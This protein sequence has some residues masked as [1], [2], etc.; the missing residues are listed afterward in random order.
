[1]CGLITRLR[2]LRAFLHRLSSNAARAA[3]LKIF[4]RRTM[5]KLLAAVVLIGG[6]SAA[7]DDAHA[8]CYRGGGYYGSY[9]GSYSQPYGSYQPYG[10]SSYYNSGPYYGSSYYSPGW[11]VGSYHGG[12]FYGGGFYGGGYHGG[13][14]HHHHHH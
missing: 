11:N 6:L 7:A 5:S 8:Q 2:L 4:R 9:Y 12:G 14:H 3:G 1:M 13:H 10:Y